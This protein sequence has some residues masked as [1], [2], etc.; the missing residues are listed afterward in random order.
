MEITKNQIDNLDLILN[1]KV[2]K[3]DI[4]T[5][6]EKKLK[7][8][9]RTQ[10][11]P[12]F[13][14][15]T[16]PMPLIIKKFGKSVFLEELS[17]FAYDQLNE[18][19]EKENIQ[20]F[21]SPI[22]AESFIPFDLEQIDNLESFD[23]PFQF[24]LKPEFDETQLYD[25]TFV[26][27]NI[28]ITDETINKIIEKY[29]KD[30]GSFKEVELADEESMLRVSLTQTDKDKNIIENG[31]T[32]EKTS[33]LVKVL[34]DDNK[35]LFIGKKAEEEI[36]VDITK[37]ITKLTELAS[38]LDKPKEEL[39][40]QE[41]FFNVKILEIKNLTPAELN[42]EFFKIIFPNDTITSEEEFRTKIDE[43]INNIYE[44]E[45]NTLLKIDI[46]KVFAEK[47]KN[48]LDLPKNFL[49]RYLQQNNEA[50]EMSEEMIEAN[51]A[52]LRWD[53]FENKI[54]IKND[55]KITYTELLN[56]AKNDIS[57]FLTQQ[58]GANYFP[59][60]MIEK[61]A[62]D[63]LKNENQTFDIENRVKN[64]KVLDIVIPLIKTEIKDITIEELKN[65]YKE[66]YGNDPE[67]EKET[68]EIE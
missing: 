52:F 36:N 40:N 19:V 62:K 11:L 8:I 32:V 34:S 7:E 51:Y 4:N 56:E 13:R 29:R 59:Q 2:E 15:G 66:K 55:I 63:Y 58:Y 65:I 35:K 21:A 50:K 43:D 26:K 45:S 27:Y 64:D 57:R 10:V 49:T 54:I 37:V 3:N 22:L 53:I 60:D 6:V 68:L 28:L 42:E 12:G 16:T 20:Y 48:I 39:E 31:I 38:M 47:L 24:G 30:A 44:N 25:S 1:V 5:I 14:P 17:K 18:Y 67:F 41:L 9:R 33:I 46:R 61:Y 23:F